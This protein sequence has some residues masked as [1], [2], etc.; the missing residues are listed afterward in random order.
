[1]LEMAAPLGRR[2]RVNIFT[3]RVDTPIWFF[4]VLLLIFGCIYFS[5]LMHMN[6]H[7]SH[8]HNHPTTE[9][10]QLQQ[11]QRSATKKRKSPLNDVTNVPIPTHKDGTELSLEERL[12]Y[13]ELKTNAHFN[14]YVLLSLSVYYFA[15]FISKLPFI[16][17]VFGLKST[18]I[19]PHTCKYI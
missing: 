18:F 9:H 11:M 13:L 16:Q 1:M 12:R 3:T 4:V 2:K 15:W 6:E 19:T 7:T 8:D 17:S 14:L 5:I 10:T